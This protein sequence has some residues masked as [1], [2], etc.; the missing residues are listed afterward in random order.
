[1]ILNRTT[2]LDAQLNE[3]QILV[4]QGK[5]DEAQIKVSRIIKGNKHNFYV[6]N[7]RGIIFLSIGK[8]LDA[9]SDFKRAIS[10]NPNFALAYNYAALCYIA[11]RNF[12]HAISFL[13]KAIKID[14]NLLEARINLGCCFRDLGKFKEA[15]IQFDYALA[16]SHSKEIL[17]QLIADI[18][19][20]LLMFDEAKQ[21]HFNAIEINPSN[22]QI[23]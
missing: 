2:K 7:Y 9:L 1:M 12:E 3:V 21:H 6:Y 8:T 10:L 13:N 19:I 18:L 17:H 4:N 22:F 11:I 15:L 14:P 5:H 20:K 23:H 16:V